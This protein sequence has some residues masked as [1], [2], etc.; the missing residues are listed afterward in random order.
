MREGRS[1]E[2]LKVYSNRSFLVQVLIGVRTAA[3]FL[4]VLVAVQSK[5]AHLES[6]NGI[7]RRRVRELEQELDACKVEVAR[8]RTRVME[9]ES[10]VVQ[11]H[12]NTPSQAQR[13]AGKQEKGKGKSIRFDDNGEAEERYREVVEEKKG[14]LFCLASYYAGTPQLI[15]YYF[16]SP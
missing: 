3:R 2:R 14:T 4:S 6:E 5:L 7:S 10:L 15:F 12:Q 9:R 11:Q 1:L 13:V 16:G 8:E